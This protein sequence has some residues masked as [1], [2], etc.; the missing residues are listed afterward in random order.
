MQEFTEHL[1][2]LPDDKIPKVFSVSWG[3]YEGDQCTIDSSG[4]C[5]SGS[6]PTNAYA[7]VANTNTGLAAAAARGITITVS[8][9]DS[10]AHGRTDSGCSSTVTRPAFPT[11]SP[12]VTSVGAT[13]LINGVQ[14]TNPKTPYCKNPSVTPCAQSGTEVVCSTA[15]GALI[16][17]GG[18]FSNVAA[19]PSWQANAVKAYLASGALLPGAGNFNASGRGYPDVSV[20]GHNYIIWIGGPT[21]VDGT[22]C[23][24]PVFAGMV[25]LWNA[26]RLKAGKPVL[27]FL[28]PMLYKLGAMGGYYHD[29][30]TGDNTCTEDGCVQGC[31]GFGATTGWDATTGWGTPNFSKIMSY[32]QSL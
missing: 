5:S 24:S 17:S 4:A 20:V 11:S 13:Q 18:G 9:G 29:V 21:Q 10:G 14:A 3:W 2:S 16:V 28:N 19:Q 22:S 8:S 25:S 32:V 15:T 27:G 31:T 23:S 1:K 6:E 26:Q 30:T 12:Y 7:Y